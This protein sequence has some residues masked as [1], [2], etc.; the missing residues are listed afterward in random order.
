MIIKDFE[1]I[2]TLAK[3]YKVPNNYINLLSFDV[4][5]KG[6]IEP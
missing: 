6:Y 4:V 2:K 1:E 5:K 3:E